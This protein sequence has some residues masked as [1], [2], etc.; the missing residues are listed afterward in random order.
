MNC[1]SGDAQKRDEKNIE[2][3]LKQ[4]IE[5]QFG[6]MEQFKEAFSS[7]SLNRFG[8]GWAW[9]IKEASGTLQ[10]ETTANAE[11][12]IRDDEKI[13]L[14]TCDVWEHAYYID[15]YNRRA[16]YLKNFWAIVNWNFVGENWKA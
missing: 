11:T 4:A 10:I 14:L 6:S 9:L 3:S 8:S 16:E 2:P 13:C 1:L 5:K 7:A 15:Y 12:P